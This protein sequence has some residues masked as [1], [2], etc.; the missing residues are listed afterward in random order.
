M[1]GLSLRSIPA[2]VLWLEPHRILSEHHQKPLSGLPDPDQLAQALLALPEGPTYWVVDDLMAPAALLRDIVELPS[3]EE[4]K[5]AFLRWRYSQHLALEGPQA[6]Q[7]LFLGEGTWL[8]AGLPEALRDQWTQ[9]AM[10]LGRPI[11]A[12]VPRWLWLYNRLAPTLEAPGMLLS[13]CPHPGGT[14]SGTLVAW[15]RTLTL[16]RQWSEPATPAQWNQE[17]VLPT[18]TYLQRES[19]APQELWIW[20][21]TS[22][23]AAAIPHHL[24]PQDIPAQEAL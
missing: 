2:Q 20:G 23:P 12:L 11:H 14:Y 21:A 9:E 24:I 16:L 7:G 18:A 17:R 5:D 6:V 19:R 1:S 3:G 8:L 15:G 4:A 13:L 22:W 10:R